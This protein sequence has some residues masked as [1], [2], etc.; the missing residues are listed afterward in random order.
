M[1][2]FNIRN[3]LQRLRSEGDLFRPV[4]GKGIDMQKAIKKFESLYKDIL[5]ADL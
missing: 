3:M 1:Q 2:D 4:L 5:N